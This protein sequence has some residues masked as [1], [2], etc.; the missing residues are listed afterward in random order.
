MKN[1]V[2]ITGA[3]K[4]FG[5][6][7]VKVFLREGNSVIAGARTFDNLMPLKEE[8]V[9]SLTMEYIDLNDESSIDTFASNINSKH[10]IDVIINNA[11]TSKG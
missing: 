10:K 5:L 9:E 11:A 7:L 4:G 2:V 3:N 1:K 6:E 8:F